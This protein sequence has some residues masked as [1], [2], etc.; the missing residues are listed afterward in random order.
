MERRKL[1]D[2]LSGSDREHLKR[3]WG[4]TRAAT[5]FA[6]LPSGEY[7]ARIIDGSAVTAKTGT[8]G[9]KLTF[10]VLEGEYADRL[11][12]H[13]VWLTPAALPMAKRDLG[14]IGVT[15]LD[16]LDQPLPKGIRC[17]ARVVLRRDDNG[18][19]TNR[20]RT[21]EVLGI[22]PPEAD[23]YAPSDSGK[24]ESL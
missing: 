22:D 10:R 12:W 9:Y 11:F 21:F 8:L 18:E 4:E 15:D 19:E 2:I 1:A 7:V 20:V 24:G 14:R 5:D 23:P 17:K 6:P 13:D 16:Q 3:A